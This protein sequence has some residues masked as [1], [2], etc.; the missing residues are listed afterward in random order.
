MGDISGKPAT[1]A[2]SDRVIISAE[3][4]TRL[5]TVLGRLIDLVQQYRI[6]ACNCG[7][8]NCLMKLSEQME[9]LQELHRRLSE[10]E[11][12]SAADIR[13]NQGSTASEL[14]L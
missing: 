8:V 3:D 9:R 12:P 2:M 4:K 10:E 11:V 5:I 14:T 13:S 6:A 7:D 1:D